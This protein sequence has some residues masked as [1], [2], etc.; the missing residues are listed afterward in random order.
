MMLLSSDDPDVNPKLVLNMIYSYRLFKH[1]YLDF[2][3]LFIYAARYSAYNCIEH[4]WTP[5]INK[6][7]GVTFNATY[8]GDKEA[9]SKMAKISEEQRKAKEKVIFDN[10]MASIKL[11]NWKDESFESFE[12]RTE[13]VPCREDDLIFKDHELAK[14]FLKCPIRDVHNFKDLLK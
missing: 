7:S 9:Q 13:V 4:L 12:I 8:P 14:A 2:L 5:L 10:A 6:L 1:L 11:D 3:A